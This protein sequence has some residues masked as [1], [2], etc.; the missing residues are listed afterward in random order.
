LIRHKSKGHLFV[1]KFALVQFAPFFENK[2]ATADYLQQLLGRIELPVDLIVFPELTLTG[3]TMR[4]QKFA[5]NMEQDSVRFFASLA[6]QYKAHIFAGFIEQAGSVF[7]NTLIHLNP[8]GQ[9]AAKYH[10]IHPFSFSGENRH[11]AAG[12]EPVI[13]RIDKFR[14]GLSVCYDLRFPE[15]F[16]FYARERVH[17]IIDIANWPH[18]RIDH[19]RTLLKA[20]SI[21]NQCY[22][23][24]VN[25]IGQDKKNEY[26]GCSCVFAPFGDIVSQAGEN[27]E[28]ITGTVSLA[29]V[30]EVQSNYP[31]LNDIVLI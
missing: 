10:K 24:G 26:R 9:V 25:R 16:R 12:T 14:I 20:R 6:G 13:T 30:T 4:S 1:L 22:V 3:F 17:I 15:L 29:R 18:S 21:E 11:Y 5:E 31:F 2:K 28:I 7:Y 27:E 19:W 8:E 23:I